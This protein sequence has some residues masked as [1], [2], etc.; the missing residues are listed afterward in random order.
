MVTKGRG[1]EY[2]RLTIF[3]LVAVM[4]L[5]PSMLVAKPSVAAKLTPME[6]AADQMLSLPLD[7]NNVW[8]IS[9][10]TIAQ[11]DVRLTFE[12]GWFISFLPLELDSG[13]ISFGGLFVGRGR[14]EYNPPISMERQQLRRFMKTDSLNRTFQQMLLIVDSSVYRQL[15][16]SA[17]LSPASP[18]N[19]K[20]IQKIVLKQLEEQWNRSFNFSALRSLA[21]PLNHDYM[22]AIV[23]LE[24]GGTVLYQN[25]PYEREQIGLFKREM[26][27]LYRKVWQ[28]LCLYSLEADTVALDF[29]GVRKSSLQ[30]VHYDMDML[31]KR[32]GEM[33]SSVTASL[34]WDSLDARA[35]DFFLGSEMEVDSVLDSVGKPI[36]FRRFK[37]SDEYYGLWLMFDDP[38]KAGAKTDLH[39]YYHGDV[40]EKE[41]G[42]YIVIAGAEWYPI[43]SE[44]ERASFDLKMRSP[45]DYT[46]VAQGALVDSHTVKDTLF[47]H[48][49]SRGEV[50]STS[51]NIGIFDRE[52]YTNKNGTVL[53]VHFCE[54]LH[55]P[56]GNMLEQVVG[57]LQGSLEFYQWLYGPLNH[58]TI[59]VSELIQFHSTSYPQYIQLSVATWDEGDMWGHQRLHRTHETAHQWFGSGVSSDNYRDYWLSEGIAEY[60]SYMYLQA[61][62]GNDQFLDRLKEHRQDILMERKNA[63]AVALGPRA[64]NVKDEDNYSIV[65]YAR[66][67]FILHMLR[68][69][70]IDLQTMKED[71]FYGLMR[72][73]YTTNN[74]KQVSTRDFQTMVEKY[75]G[76]DMGWFFNQWVYNNYIPTYDFD[77]T[78][79]PDS[80]GG[81][82]AKLHI[83]QREVPADFRMYV[84]VAIEMDGGRKAYVR[85]LVEQPDNEF[86]LKLPEKPKKITLNPFLSVLAE[87]N[88]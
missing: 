58:D 1:V 87:V 33:F 73:W 47:S 43:G 14:M 77:Y 13:K 67:A 51:F 46:M 71:R 45:S 76:V 5:G 69:L 15:T 80:A 52:Y 61:V 40:A 55:R 19:F 50:K 3:A 11:R 37:E 25:D 9:N 74:G 65:V 44:R 28:T 60:S 34:I 36:P 10:Q 48:W 78:V 57:D 53:D 64:Y 2:A 82:V 26:E 66:G 6:Q 86:E 22:L 20:P 42:V 30:F 70:L 7:S 39:F 16:A 72:D 31:V 79:A 41:L 21:N 75:A 12:T 83:V 85:M 49:Q 8:E 18:I 38:P 88:Q 62:A 68:N 54:F 35:F 63:G 23:E 56:M 17:K 32:N 4:L 81:F 24:Q 59:V 27:V 84:P 29:N